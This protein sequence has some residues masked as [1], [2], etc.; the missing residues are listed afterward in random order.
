MF[1]SAL[2]RS[3]NG[4][5]TLRSIGEIDRALSGITTQV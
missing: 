5:S 3:I 1:T 4:R 2:A